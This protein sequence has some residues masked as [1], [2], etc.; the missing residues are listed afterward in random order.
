MGIAFLGA[1]VVEPGLDDIAG[2]DVAFEQKV[3][4][5]LQGIERGFERSGT[6]RDLGQL[7][8]GKVVEILVERLAR[9]DL[10]HD[11]IEA[12]HQHR[13]EGQVR[14]AGGIGEADFDALGLGAGE[15]TGMR[16]AAERLREE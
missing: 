14:I 4:V 7:F 9:V 5:F 6:A 15:Y 13:R 16:I 3:V 2:E 8:G 11:A 1:L 12:R 10:V